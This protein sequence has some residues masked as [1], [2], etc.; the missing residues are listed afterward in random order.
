MW[1]CRSKPSTSRAKTSAGM[2]VRPTSC[3]A[4]KTRERAS[5]SELATSSK[6][7]LSKELFEDRLQ[8]SIVD[9][10]KAAVPQRPF[11]FCSTI[12]TETREP[13]NDQTRTSEQH[14]AQGSA[15]HH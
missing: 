10:K 2:V 1:R 15:R 5:A 6:E 4:W 7:L 3:G 11:S 14:R 9:T 12:S 8:R 13:G